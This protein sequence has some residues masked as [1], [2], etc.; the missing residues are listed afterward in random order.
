MNND[1][2]KNKNIEKIKTGVKDLS[3]ETLEKVGA[4][5]EESKKIIVRKKKSSLI[6]YQSGWKGV[7]I[8][9][10]KTYKVCNI[11]KTLSKGTA[12]LN[13]VFNACELSSGYLEEKTFISEPFSKSLFSVLGSIGG[14][15]VGTAIGSFLGSFFPGPGTVIGGII[16]G[17]LGGTIAGIAGEKLGKFSYNR[18]FSHKNQNNSYQSNNNILTG[19]GKTGGV[20]FEIPKEI[21]YFRK[22]LFFNQDFHQNIVFDT[23]FSNLKEILDVTNRFLILK[24]CKFN[25]INEVF[26]T[27]LTEIY[28]GFIGEGVLPYVSLNFNNDA[29]LY[30]IMPNYYKKT[31]T[32]NILGYLDYFL[33]C[34]V[35]GGFFKEEFTKE[36]YKTKNTDFNYLNSNFINLKKYIFQNKTKIKNHDLYMT[37]YDLGENISEDNANYKNSMSAF[38]IIGIINNDIFVHKNMIIPN[39]A[40]RTESDFNLFHEYKN[41]PND[42]NKDKDEKSDVEK[43]QDAIKKMKT[44]INLLMPQ[45]PYFRGYFHILDMITFA[46]HYISTLDSN[47]VFPDFSESFLIKSN[48]KSYVYLLPPVFPPLPIKKQIILSVNLTFSYVINNF[49]ND[50]E[51]KLLNNVLSESVL[52]NSE[53]NIQKIEQILN[54]LETKYKNYLYKLLNNKDEI[55]YRTRRELKIDEFIKKI[56]IIFQ[57]LIETPK[58][59]CSNIYQTI[60]KTL[61][62]NLKEY[63][64]LMGT[65]F[66]YS[67]KK[68]NINDFE[69]IEEKKEQ[70][71][72]LI[73]EFKN[74]MKKFNNVLIKKLEDDFQ[75]E[76]I[77][78]QNKMNSEKETAYQNSIRILNQNIEN[79]K[80]KTYEEFKNNLERQLNSQK[81]SLL[82]DVPYYQRIDIELKIE[83]KISEIKQNELDKKW[84]EINNFYENQKYEKQTTI[85]KEIE[86]KTNEIIQK[87]NN[88]FFEEKNKK[89][90]N[91][92]SVLIEEIQK[93]INDFNSKMKE[94]EIN[95]K[96]K[97]ILNY[98][99]LY[100]KKYL[101]E[102]INLSLMGYYEEKSND[103]SIIKAPVRGGCL[104]EINNKLEFEDISEL[105]T[106]ANLYNKINENKNLEEIKIDET[107]YI[108]IN[109]NLI[110]GNLNENFCKTFLRFNGSS[111]MR[112]MEMINKNENVT[113]Q[114]ELGN[115]SGIY[116]IISQNSEKINGRNEIIQKN[117]LGENAAFYLDNDDDEAVDKII[118]L[119]EKS[120]FQTETENNLNPF[121]ISIMN[122]RRDMSNT[123]LN[124]ISTKTI[125]SSNETKITPLHYACLYNYSELANSLIEKGANVNSKTREF[126][127]TPL[128]FLV[129]TGNYETLQ[130]LLKY[131]SIL[132]LINQTNNF[133]S[134]P[135]HT[136][137]SE[138]ML[139]TK[140]LLKNRNKIPDI[141]GNKPEHYAFLAGRIDIYNQITTSDIKEF[142]QY[143]LSIREG[144]TENL[145]EEIIH[146][147]D[148][149]DLFLSNLNE[150]LK[151]EI[152]LI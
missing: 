45:I 63:N 109:V 139:C 92:N 104:S 138:S 34:F 103:N 62:L 111:E 130:I 8:P 42:I 26:Q 53:I 105:E 61:E 71:Y 37:V 122:Q 50:N 4:K 129:Q 135:F 72:I 12:L 151:K 23:G 47:A 136:A 48:G 70:I 102:K 113:I 85:W 69:K 110:Q 56:I 121:L 88:S 64:K 17:F 125:N 77:K 30:S 142:N 80:N 44:I 43:T 40:F 11:G 93:E 127:D 137:C 10:I 13:I 5:L 94:L 35:N 112:I 18:F 60:T 57:A 7:S 65:K 54:V 3:L 107:N 21:K 90:K 82:D 152:V 132:N 2:E 1:D 128:D 124:H 68:I 28:G 41:K 67:L 79:L 24:N 116:K 76:K 15:K 51:K 146:K 87:T 20:E 9:K 89:I 118:S 149:I 101:V 114:D 22:V 49:L 6:R 96:N 131:K 16:G 74:I 91:L 55:E 52:N 33:K 126:G 140:L 143:I 95:L 133:K 73:N 98:A 108:K 83:S 25:S 117:Y 59:L 32:G 84:R 115:S 36:W 145:N 123:L 100:D 19:G 66:N 27:I 147:L 81:N 38:R 39:C 31:L 29:L 99:N 106:Y 97:T 14:A 58:F 144:D 150:S 75:R 78:F 120:V 141:N 134:T 148:N 46:I 119:G 86:K